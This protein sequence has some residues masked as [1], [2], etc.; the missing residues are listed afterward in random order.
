MQRGVF[1]VHKH[2]FLMPGH[3]YVRWILSNKTFPMCTS[4]NLIHSNRAFT[5]NSLF[6]CTYKYEI[7]EMCVCVCVIKHSYTEIF[8]AALYN[9]GI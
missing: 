6:E 5:I 7:N 3:L 8:V 9:A 2:G 1:C 4:E